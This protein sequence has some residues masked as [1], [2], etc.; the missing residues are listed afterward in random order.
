MARALLQPSRVVLVDEA[1]ANV[2]R[3]T[4]AL[5]QTILKHELRD[6]TVITIAHRLETIIDGDL[7]V[8]MER[9]ECVEYGSPQELLNTPGGLFRE[10]WTAQKA[11][12]D[13]Q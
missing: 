12:T 10:M 6:K 8:V 3:H 2:D 7:I 13:Q 5:I 1:T 11:Q 9:G 4:D